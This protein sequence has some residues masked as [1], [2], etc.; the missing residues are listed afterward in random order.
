MYSKRS[1]KRLVIGREEGD[2]SQ[3]ISKVGI[4]GAGRE[5]NIDKFDLLLH[6]AKET[7]DEFITL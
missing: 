6:D 7:R 4:C 5:T 2:K 3:L 1:N